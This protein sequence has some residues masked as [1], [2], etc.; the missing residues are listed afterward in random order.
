MAELRHR[1]CS[2]SRENHPMKHFILIAV[3]FHLFASCS[4]K[5]INNTPI[6][7][8]DVAIT[9]ESEPIIASIEIPEDPLE[10][11]Y[12]S[13]NVNSPEGLNVRKN[14]NITA[15]KIYL[16]ED[17]QEVR[18]IEA[19]K[20]NITIDNINGYWALIESD[21]IKGWVFSGYLTGGSNKY[22]IQ[23]DRGIIQSIDLPSGETINKNNYVVKGYH[24]NID[25]IKLYNFQTTASSY[26]VIENVYVMLFKTDDEGWL[27]L[28]TGDMQK[29][30]F[31]RIQDISMESF[32]GDPERNLNSGNYY[33]KRLEQERAIIK[34]NAAI[35]RYGPLLVIKSGDKTVKIWDE[36]TNGSSIKKNLLVDVLDNN[37]LVILRQFYE[38][39]HYY[40][41]NIDQ[42]EMVADSL[43]RPLF[44]EIKTFFVSYGS[45]YNETPV[46]E[47]FSIDRNKYQ[48]EKE[49]DIY[50]LLNIR[51]DYY[52]S[53]EL[54]WEGNNKLKLM[55]EDIGIYILYYEDS[56]WHE[57]VRTTP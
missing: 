45:P 51:M 42:E 34:S 25:A 52:P 15:E 39:V 19:D 57:E 4:K 46:L 55:Y 26:E 32:Y 56:I 33:E 44:N 10:V 27:C 21:K 53:Y 48:I 49:V 43:E 22:T 40:I 17:K 7:N 31:I 13:M 3:F 18:I 2:I 47:L 36:F 5:E 1:A 28:L 8:L 6:D 9:K 14:P 54:E 50:P 11:R 35:K 30:G 24:Y 16:L 23:R 41:F 29:F 37:D 12:T 38:V 20:N